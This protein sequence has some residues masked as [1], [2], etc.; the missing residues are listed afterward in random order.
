MP[1]HDE[2]QVTEVSLSVLFLHKMYGSLT[3]DPLLSAFDTVILL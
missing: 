1:L 2:P 3:T